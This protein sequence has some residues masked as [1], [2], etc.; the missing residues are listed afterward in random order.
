MP[1]YDDAPLLVATKAK[2]KKTI[3]KQPAPSLPPPR[4]VPLPVPHHPSK[5][6]SQAGCPME[7]SSPLALILTTADPKC[8][9]TS[10]TIQ[11]ATSLNDGKNK[12]V[13]VRA[14]RVEA[15]SSLARRIIRRWGLHR[16]PA[17]TLPLTVPIIIMI[18]TFRLIIYRLHCTVLYCAVGRRRLLARN[19]TY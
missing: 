17:L 10:D 4:P 11:S 15:C 19:W 9:N 16:T 2:D 5:H 13:D 6:A 14:R 7:I 12:I 18:I 1:F 3:S 8:M